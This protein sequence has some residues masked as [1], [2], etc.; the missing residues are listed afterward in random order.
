MLID[1]QQSQRTAGTY[2]S[3]RTNV[4]AGTFLTTGTDGSRLSTC[5]APPSS[6][7]NESARAPKT[8]G[9]VP[10]DAELNCALARMEETL[11]PKARK[12]RVCGSKT[13]SYEAPT[14]LDDTKNARAPARRGELHVDNEFRRATTSIEELSPTSEGVKMMK[15]KQPSNRRKAPPRMFGFFRRIAGCPETTADPP[16]TEIIEE[17]PAFTNVTS[18]HNQEL[19][20]ASSQDIGVLSKPR[21]NKTKPRPALKQRS[22]VQ[23]QDG[24]TIF[25]AFRPYCVDDGI[26]ASELPSEFDGWVGSVLIV[27]KNAPEQ[28][29]E[30]TTTRPAKQRSMAQ[31]TGKKSVYKQQI[32]CQS[33]VQ[34]WKQSSRSISTCQIIRTEGHE[35]D[36]STHGAVASQM[37]SP[38]FVELTSASSSIRF[39]SDQLSIADTSHSF[40]VSS[41]GACCHP[42][43]LRACSSVSSVTSSHLFEITTISGSSRLGTPFAP[44]RLNVTTSSHSVQRLKSQNL[45]AQVSLDIDDVPSL[46]LLQDIVAWRSI[47]SRDGA[48][49]AAKRNPSL[50]DDDEVKSFDL[51]P[52]LQDLT[53]TSST[54][55]TSHEEAAYVPREGLQ[56]TTS[57]FSRRS[58]EW[59]SINAHS[60]PA[61]P[62]SP[63]CNSQ[64]HLRATTSSSSCLS[65]YIE[66]KLAAAMTRDTRS[67][68][69]MSLGS[70]EQSSDLRIIEIAPGVEVP[71]RGA[72]ETM[73]Y[74]AAAVTCELT[75][76]A[77]CACWTCSTTIH[78]VKDAAYILCPMCHTVQ[79]TDFD[80]AWGVGLGFLPSDWDEW[81]AAL[82]QEAQ[83]SRPLSTKF[84]VE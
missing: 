55:W 80:I 49:T 14:P 41:T 8:I 52:T 79:P 25:E 69:E 64:P 82:T 59:W 81:N 4:T 10:M 32:S 33:L 28:Q 84:I 15:V 47:Q 74:V 30:S 65:D 40:D 43:F 48:S 19:E 62:P 44:P 1:R 57:S 78:C 6:S 31:S 56:V 13:S 11:S 17:A 35:R 36:E 12:G 83:T 63:R 20:V 18:Q 67:S 3:M 75:L 21:S 29:G 66:R 68:N 26:R 71:M 77:T 46:P 34:S 9:V 7:A 51:A 24:A 42:T 53:P 60:C 16:N 22:L 37:Q 5:E 76:I 58:L 54:Q 70:L 72:E 50:I 45:K 73:L 39:M 23:S 61:V 2:R 27:P 38:T